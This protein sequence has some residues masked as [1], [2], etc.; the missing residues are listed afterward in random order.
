MKK[1][2]KMVF[3][4]LFFFEIPAVFPMTIS[5]EKVRTIQQYNGNS[6]VEFKSGEKFTIHGDNTSQ[7]N[8]YTVFS[9]NVN[10]DFQGTT[11]SADVVKLKQQPDG[12]SRLE[13]TGFMLEK[14]E[15]T[16][17]SRK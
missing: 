11:L 6:V 1:L 10:I 7:E 15:E 14:I 17:K 5:A 2:F 8:G 12:S 13:A 9:G 3:I 4:T 16:Q